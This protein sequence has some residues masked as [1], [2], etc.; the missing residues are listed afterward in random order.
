MSA[1]R[2]MVAIAIYGLLLAAPAAG[3]E[4]RWPVDLDMIAKIREEGL[5]RSDLPNTFS[6]MTDVI[7]ARLTNSDD[8]VQAQEWVV[9]EM[10]RMGLENV[11]R[12]PFMDYGVSWDNEYVSLHML[13]PDYSPMVG[14][15]IAH[16]P[17]TEGR[18]QLT[19]VIGDVH[20]RA[21]L[22]RYRGKLRGLAV[23]STPPA[24]VDQRRFQT[25]TPRRTAEELRELE[26][27]VI[28]P[29]PGPDPYFSRLYPPPPSNPEVLTAAEKLNF[30]VEEGAAVVLESSSGWPGAVRGFARAGAKIDRWA[31]DE[32]LGSSRPVEMQTAT[33]SIRTTQSLA[34]PDT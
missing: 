6:Y 25:G 16:T 30:Y 33:Q 2:V 9:A 11:E 13:E 27:D 3:Q 21:D 23:L 20:T 31:R 4:T 8:M 28:V 29:P 26:Q 34:P 32:T 19:T 22:E 10:R 17:G 5:Q 15:P 24:T 18:Q 1:R 12:E 14:Y 7:G